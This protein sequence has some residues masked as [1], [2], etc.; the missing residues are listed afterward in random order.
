MGLVMGLAMAMT[1]DS[2]LSLVRAHV[3]LSGLGTMAITGIVYIL[4]PGSGRN[5]LARLHFSGHNIGL[6][7]MMAG[8]RRAKVC[9]LRRT[10][11]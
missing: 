7:E 3:T 8:W 6:P 4:V 10:L 2:T 9:D 5:R 1:K 11:I